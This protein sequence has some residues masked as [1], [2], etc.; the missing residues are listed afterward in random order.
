MCRSLFTGVTVGHRS[1]VRYYRQHLK[2]VKYETG[3][4]RQKREILKKAMIWHY[5]ELGWKGTS[6]LFLDSF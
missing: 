3:N 5:K 4:N 6:G 1:L 2:P